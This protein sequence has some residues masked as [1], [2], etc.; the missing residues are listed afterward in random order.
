MFA[1]GV[2]IDGADL[3]LEP[4]AAAVAAGDGRELWQLDRGSN[5][6]FSSQYVAEFFIYLFLPCT[7]RAIIDALSPRTG[8]ML[9]SLVF[10]SQ[11]PPTPMS[12]LVGAL[13]LLG[14]ASWLDGLHHQE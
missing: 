4:C 9:F 11:H 1:G 7:P 5:C 10:A 13:V 3:V 14:M 8:K 6:Y 2:D 12:H